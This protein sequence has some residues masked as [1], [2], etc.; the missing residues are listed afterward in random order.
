MITKYGSGDRF[1]QARRQIGI[2]QKE[3]AAVLDVSPAY[4]SLIATDR[5]PMSEPIAFKMEKLFRFS[6]EWILYE[7]G[8]RRIDSNPDDL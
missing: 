3:L 4:L 6:A 2:T 1:K 8:P 7:K 5:Q